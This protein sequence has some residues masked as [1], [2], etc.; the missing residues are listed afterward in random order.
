MSRDHQSNAAA[1]FVAV[2]IAALVLTLWRLWV[3]QHQD[4]TL[5]YDEAQYWDW[6]RDLALGY[7]SKPPLIAWL[8]AAGTAWAG[9]GVLGVKLAPMLLYP[10]TALVLWALGR[11]LHPRAGL[12]AALIFLSLPLTGLLGLYASTD[13]PLLLCWA[14]SAWALWRAQK[15][16]AP[17]DWA[18]LG[19]AAGLGLLSKYTMAAF[20]LSA[21]PA[22][23]LVPGPRRGVLRPGPWIAAAIAL[24]VLAPNLW[25]NAQHA[26]PTLQHTADITT[27][28]RRHG[29]LPE[30]AEFLAGQ[31]LVLGPLAAWLAFKGFKRAWQGWR[32]QDANAKLHPPLE[33]EPA[34][35]A[36]AYVP[37]LILP[38]IAMATAQSWLA[39]ANLNW[40]APAHVGTCLLL[41]LVMVAPSGALRRGLLAATVVLNLALVAVTVHAGDIYRQLGEPLPGKLDAL[42][43]MRGWD[44]AFAQL[45][46]ALAAGEPGWL[47]GRQPLVL[48]D[49]RLLLAQ[50]AYQWRE[51]GIRP[52]AWKPEARVRDHYEL[53]TKLEPAPGQSV[54]LLSRGAAPDDI[55]ARFDS[56]REAAIVRVEVAPGRHVEIHATEL[57]G[58]R[59]YAPAA[60]ASPTPRPADE[61]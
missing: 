61:Q 30:A 48:S 16:D 33:D 28:A 24:A 3:V 31:I 11:E 55:A 43:R 39:R 34:L 59:G 21:V 12:P 14:L 51:R 2:L 23:W 10:L 35:G 6:S 44:R 45:G 47:G 9:D 46:Q 20:V 25:W 1:E 60:A 7:Y 5:F 38:L 53:T 17:G 41:G 8:I 29:G 37:L 27:R 22:L 18:L 4:W 58:F 36:W 57:R 26:F 32:E 13:A 52:V 54:W 40:A 19:L 15:S 42:V 49:D 50:T 56:A